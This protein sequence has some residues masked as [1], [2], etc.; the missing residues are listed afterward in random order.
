[1]KKF[2]ALDPF[3]E[4]NETLSLWHV[5]VVPRDTDHNSLRLVSRWGEPLLL[6]DGINM[7]TVIRR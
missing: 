5:R 6:A 7:G 2:G 4:R 1:M 3:Q